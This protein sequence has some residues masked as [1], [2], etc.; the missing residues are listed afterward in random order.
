ML[1]GAHPA[2]R[3]LVASILGAVGS[4]TILTRAQVRTIPP[5]AVF[6]VTPRD[7]QQLPI[8][9][10]MFV[11]R[12][13]LPATPALQITE[14]RLSLSPAQQSSFALDGVQLET[15]DGRMQ[16]AAAPFCVAGRQWLEQPIRL[17]YEGTVIGEIRIHPEPRPAGSMPYTPPGAGA[18][19]F[20][21]P[22]YQPGQP[23]AIWGPFGDAG[24][25]TRVEVNGKPGLVLSRTPTELYW[26]LPPDTPRGAISVSVYHAGQGATFRPFFLGLSMSAQKLTLLKG[27]ST[28]MQATVFGP[29]MLR[30][31]DWV[32]GGVPDVL[33]MGR[34][35]E[36]FPGYQIPKPG[37]AGK[38]FFRVDNLSRDAV[39]LSPS[40]N[41]SFVTTLDRSSFAAGPYTYAGTIH[42][43]RAGNFNING[44]VVAFFA[45]VA[46]VP[47]QPPADAPTPPTEVP[48]PPADAPRPPID[49]P[50]VPVQPPG[51]VP[52]V[53]PCENTGDSC[54]ESRRLAERLEEVAAAARANAPAA[55]VR[56]LELADAVEADR[57]A[58]GAVARAARLRAQARAY[59]ELAESARAAAATDR[60]RAAQSPPGS[61]MRSFW[62][63]ESVIDE[64]RGSDTD[65]VA[66]RQE[67]DAATEDARA[68]VEQD[69]AGALRQGTDQS[70]SSGLDSAIKAAADARAAYNDC[71]RKANANCP[72][73]PWTF[74]L[75][76]GL[77]YS[78][79]RPTPGP[80]WQPP[81]AAAKKPDETCSYQ[82]TDG[83]LEPTQGVWQ[84]DPDFDDRPGKQ[85]T[86][87][88]I[89]GVVSYV[90]E[91]PMVKGRDTVIVGVDH[92]RLNGVSVPVQSRNA[93]V[94]KGLSNC[95]AFDPVDVRVSVLGPAGG[96]AG[97]AIAS[98]H[99]PMHGEKLGQMVPWTL[100]ALAFTGL[101]E[102]RTFTFG[103]T[104]P[105]TIVAEIATA[106]GGTGMQ[107]R[108]SGNVVDTHGPTVRF[109]PVVVQAG[110]PDSALA[111]TAGKLAADSARYLPDLLPLRPGGLPT[112]ADALKDF[113]KDDLSSVWFG[114]RR[115]RR[116][117]ALVQDHLGVSAFL[118]GAGRVVAVLHPADFV[119]LEGRGVAGMAPAGSF[120]T[121]ESGATLSHKVILIP[122]TSEINVVGHELAH[123]L[124]GLWSSDEMVAECGINYH[125]KSTSLA[126]GMRLVVGGVPSVRQF[127]DGSSPIMGPRLGGSDEDLANPMTEAGVAV[128]KVLN[129][130]TGQTENQLTFSQ[131][132]TQCTYGHLVNVLQMPPDPPML[133]VRGFVGRRDGRYTASLNA[134]YDL[135]GS[136]DLPRDF[137]GDFAILLKDA[138]GRPLA[139]Y[140]FA[141][142]WSVPGMESARDL[143]AFAFRVPKMDG[144]A[145][146]DLTGPAGVLASTAISPDPPR[147]EILGPAAGETVTPESGSVAV[148]WRGSGD[149]GRALVYSVLYSADG[150]TNWG[151]RVFERAA[152]LARVAISAQSRTHA[153]KVIASDGTRSAEAT[154]RFA[155][156]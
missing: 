147:I 14:T 72:V 152:T 104:G 30:T 28:G 94:M 132:I 53:A 135:M 46:G 138:G 21:A 149:A 110:G 113:T 13:M 82:L 131:W 80:D 105:Y 111:L 109:I 108:V 37:E 70:A 1:R 35:A 156:R 60:E 84:D 6:T 121:A 134:F 125:N 95:S 88:S 19:F 55:S 9:G 106:K 74:P 4:A 102:G 118:T 119:L 61:E 79:D 42:S 48:K 51:V 77:T 7:I 123:T 83:W 150:G 90:A 57:A 27:E 97:F 34:V 50:I 22:L 11:D 127:K 17:H 5:S 26:M 63:Q 8:C 98:G 44:L 133:L 58:A 128:R 151:E 146:V 52:P 68:K 101:P 18:S 66:K 15:G 16:P 67:T 130:A 45:P 39:K 85:L 3:V 38:L 96:G 115:E 2:V 122:S 81:P 49:T 117:L 64:Q 116:L 91:L 129:P 137:I 154:V 148:T 69:R 76:L 99:I 86:R 89:P 56:Q 31:E 47:V 41:E 25:D 87:L 29:E 141:P 120:R 33:D 78:W 112:R 75:S 10:R 54:A 155:T 65:A 140:A 139:R 142:D 144:L 153:I 23:Q 93:V 124:P 114:F 36:Q 24:A 103:S 145:Q 62:E 71:V 136:E 12:A 40:K 20:T 92:Y 32:A 143:T 73:R 126:H 43:V 107:M 59:R 100:S